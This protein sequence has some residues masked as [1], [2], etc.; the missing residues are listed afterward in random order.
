MESKIII[1]MLNYLRVY[2]WTF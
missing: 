1:A 2:F